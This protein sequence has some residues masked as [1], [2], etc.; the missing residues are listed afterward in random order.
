MPR[1]EKQ[2]VVRWFVGS[3]VRWFVG[4]LVR[5]FV[6]QRA[7]SATTASADDEQAFVTTVS[8]SYERTAPM[9]SCVAFEHG[10]VCVSAPVLT[11]GC[12]AVS[13]TATSITF[14]WPAATSSASVTY[15]LTS[16]T[17][18]VA[19]ASTNTA[20]VGSLTAATNYSYSLYASTA[21]SNSQSSSVSCAGWTGEPFR[22]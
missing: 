22:L 13:S 14:Q 8:P 10:P 7:P 15:Y 17:T 20:T 6:R 3:L 16:G 2:C 11:S 19:N 18:I 5:W 12:Q 1:R 4:S 21:G 9:W